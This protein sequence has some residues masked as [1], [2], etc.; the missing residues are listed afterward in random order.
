MNLD[1]C[2]QA[3]LLW[4]AS[5]RPPFSFRWG[6][7]SGSGR[8]H[9]CFA[10]SGMWQSS[11]CC[12]APLS[13]NSFDPNFTWFGTSLLDHP[14]YYKALFRCLIIPST[15]LIL[16]SQFQI[17]TVWLML[18][19]SPKSVE[20]LKEVHTKH[21]ASIHL[22]QSLVIFWSSGKSHSQA[23][24]FPFWLIM[25]IGFIWTIGKYFATIINA[26]IRRRW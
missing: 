23:V 4:I 17:S 21:T 15:Y 18:V 16:L 3:Q 8:P 20:Y 9:L 19:G 6:P 13:R 14:A 26:R 12:Q 1:F 22:H 11:L 10:P 25:N 7:F 5:N 24:W 2:L